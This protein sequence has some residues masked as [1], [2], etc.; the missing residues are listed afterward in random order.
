MTRV[1]WLQWR[2]TKGHAML[3]P[4]CQGLFEYYTNYFCLLF[5]FLIS[6]SI[7]VEIYG[8]KMAT[9][10]KFSV[11]VQSDRKKVLKFEWETGKTTGYSTDGPTLKNDT[12]CARTLT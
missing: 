1:I 5:F 10:Y 8:E 6:K 11:E 4:S 3:F 7:S 12:G 9:R 2:R